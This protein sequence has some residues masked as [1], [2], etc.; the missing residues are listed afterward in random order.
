MQ[1]EAQKRLERI[2]EVRAQGNTAGR[3]GQ[4]DLHALGGPSGGASA[5]LGYGVG[6]LEASGGGVR[7]RRRVVRARAPRAVKRLA[8]PRRRRRL[9]GEI[10]GGSDA[11]DGGRGGASS[12]SKVP[13]QSANPTI[14]LVQ[15]KETPAPGKKSKAS[16]GALVGGEIVGGAVVGGARPKRKLS[17]YN[18]FVRDFSRKYKG[19]S[20]GRM[21]AA[22]A[23]WNKLKKSR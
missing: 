16:G 18:V 10:V 21:V 19:P 20:S 3:T 1:T 4:E 15:D 22:A 7:R 5:V 6:P 9:A 2:L 14:P 11:Y 8:A 13:G 12:A 17:A 23:A